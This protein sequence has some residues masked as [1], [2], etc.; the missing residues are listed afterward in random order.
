MTK[1]P[2]SLYKLILVDAT[3]PQFQMVET[4]ISQMKQEIIEIKNQLKL[5]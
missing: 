4:D 3:R 5:A 1:N 2:K